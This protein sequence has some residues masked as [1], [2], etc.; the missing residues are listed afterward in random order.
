MMDHL[1][2][3]NMEA[4]IVDIIEYI[5]DDMNRD[6]LGQ[7]PGR[8]VRSWDELYSG[9]RVTDE[10]IR[11]VLAWFEDPTDEMVIVKGIGFYSTCEHHMLPFFGTV[12]IGYIPN[13]RIIGVSKLARLVEVFARRLQVQE[14]LTRDIAT[15]IREAFW[16]DVAVQITGQHLCMM[17]R[18]VRQTASEM[19]TTQLSGDFKYDPQTRS[20]FLEGIK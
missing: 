12:A 7:T 8:V 2:R 9:Y 3:D 1:T 4:S 18:G 11:R 17:A 6:G 5:G 20:E 15:V 19:V 10:E 16:E 13:G 14:R